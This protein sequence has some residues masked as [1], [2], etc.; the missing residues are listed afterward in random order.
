MVAEQRRGRLEVGVGFC[1]E[2]GPRE[3][4]EDYVGVFQGGADQLARFGVVAAVAD[5]VGGHKGGRVAAELAVRGFID[6]HLG[7]SEMLGVRRTSARSIEAVN[8][9][10]HKLGRLDPNLEGM[11]CT[12]T[13]LVLRGR[14]AHVVHVGDSR[15]YRLREDRLDLLTTDH[16]W[17]QPGMKNVLQRAV[18]AA[19]GVQIDYAADAGRVHDRYL[20][21]SD[22]VHAYVSNAVLRRELARR[23]SPDETARAIVAAAAAARTGDNATALVLDVLDLPPANRIDLELEIAAQPIIAPPRAGITVDGFALDTVLSDGRYT[24]VFKGR[25]TLAGRDVIV[26]FP[27]PLTGAEDVLRQAFLRETWISARLRSPWVGE[28]IMVP[29]ERRSCL[30]LVL[31]FYSGE[32]MEARLLRP[33]RLAL[34]E[35][36]DMGV[37]LARGV[38]ALHRAG[39]I[40]RD[41]KPENVIIER[42]EGGKIGVRLIDLGVARLPNIDDFGPEHGP[43]T[44]SYMAPE[45]FAGGPGDEQADQFALGVTIYRLFTGAYPYGEIEPFTKPRFGRPAPLSARRPDLPAWLDQALARA[46]AVNP[47]ERF[48]DV[49]EFAF[50]LEHGAIRAAPVLPQRRPIYA[51][52]PL[53]FWQVISALLALAVIVLLALR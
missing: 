31:P 43:G 22:G 27:K 53:L 20:L 4:N 35:G 23:A 50:E 48:G 33:P 5:G 6:G 10:I 34:A 12:L 42:S 49:L 2:R 11:A 25:D 36:L 9:W 3:Q 37:K 1:S 7:Q 16:A 15:L 32:T 51:R 52:N 28:M 41:I 8:S 21:C 26:K 44:P 30:Y 18:G 17:T 46:V 24:R 45:L 19:D 40:H 13:A 39:I 29:P 14:Q 47:D 38:A